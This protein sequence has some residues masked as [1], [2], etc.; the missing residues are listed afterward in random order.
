LGWEAVAARRR[1]VRVLGQKAVVDVADKCREKALRY[2][3]RQQEAAVAMKLNK[4][5]SH[6][7]RVLVACAS[8]GDALKKVADLATEL[9]L[10][11]QNTFKIVH[12]LSRAGFVE[13]ERGRYGGVRL[14][15]PAD[16]IKVGNVV[17]AMELEPDQGNDGITLLADPQTPLLDA[18][19]GAFIA[20]LNQTT[21][22]DMARAQKPPARSG[23]A[24]KPKAGK[25]RKVS[26]A[27]KPRGS[28]RSTS[29]TR[30]A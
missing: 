25:P 2:L 3:R 29:P 26:R 16:A 19:F 18:A 7:L 20:V 5:T 23:R 4:A 1:V 10:S 6:A 17:K 8:A 21:I 28:A 12:L 9:D 24:K 11:Q 27:A 14:A 15:H 13:G 30:T 22:A